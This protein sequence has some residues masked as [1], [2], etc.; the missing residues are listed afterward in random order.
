MVQT[1]C[2]HHL[3]ANKTL[4]G[5]QE[6]ASLGG[7]VLDLEILCLSEMWVIEYLVT[8]F[9][10]TKEIKTLQKSGAGWIEGLIYK[11]AEVQYLLRDW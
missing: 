1:H 4:R 5:S 6:A 2:A 7:K 8:G 9:G 3:R 11:S 10:E